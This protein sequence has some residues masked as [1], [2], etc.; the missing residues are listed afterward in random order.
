MILL[1]EKTAA[2]RQIIK[3]T[4]KTLSNLDVETIVPQHQ[5]VQLRAGTH[6][7]N[8]EK[9]PPLFDLRV[10]HAPHPDRLKCALTSDLASNQAPQ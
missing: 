6:S 4:T 2:K 10:A 1:K 9:R 8:P 5:H 7:A 3:R